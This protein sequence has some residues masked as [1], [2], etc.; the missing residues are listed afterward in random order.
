MK[1]RCTLTYGQ[2][3]SNPISVRASFLFGTN[4]AILHPSAFLRYQLIICKRLKLQVKDREHVLTLLDA[5]LRDVRTKKTY[6]H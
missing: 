3:L 4:L 1:T 5:F 2:A 6:A